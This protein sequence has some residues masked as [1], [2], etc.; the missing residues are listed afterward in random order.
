[1]SISFITSNLINVGLHYLQI[2]STG[3]STE[4]YG[5]SMRFYFQL[6]RKRGKAERERMCQLYKNMNESVKD[7]CIEGK[8][9]MGQGRN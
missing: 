3:P 5:R 2:S 9:S 4:T 6:V 7:F 1:M 8:Y